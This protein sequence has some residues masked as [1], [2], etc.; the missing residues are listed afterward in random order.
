MNVNAVHSPAKLCVLFGILLVVWVLFAAQ[1]TKNV[2]YT[3]DSTR[4]LIE[5]MREF[6]PD[7]DSKLDDLNLLNVV[8]YEN[9]ILYLITVNVFAI[10]TV[11][12]IH[13]RNIL[14][15]ILPRSPPL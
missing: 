2:E 14:I 6:D 11:N 15:H 3:D 5:Q 7:N 8:F 12:I 1:F 10:S 13:L 4:V 9:T